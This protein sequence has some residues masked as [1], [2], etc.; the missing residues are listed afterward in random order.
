MNANAAPQLMHDYS[1][2]G[3]LVSL[4]VMLFV[5]IVR[6]GRKHP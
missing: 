2:A 6:W 5:G 3:G 4:M 1:F